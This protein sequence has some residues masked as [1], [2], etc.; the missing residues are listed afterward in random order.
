MVIPG[1]FKAPATAGATGV[2]PPKDG[3]PTPSPAVPALAEK[4]SPWETVEEVFKA[5]EPWALA[6]VD[7]LAGEL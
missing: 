7:P 4:F 5:A 1:V 2:W 3:K 6:C